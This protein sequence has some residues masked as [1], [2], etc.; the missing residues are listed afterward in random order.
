MT[1]KFLSPRILNLDWGRIQIDGFGEFKDVKLYPGGARNWS[2]QETGTEHSPGVQFADVQELLDHGAEE[3]ILTR[4]I[5]GRLKVQHETVSKLEDMG[6]T[7]H[8][9]HTKE[10]VKL[11]NVLREEKKVGGLFHNTC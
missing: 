10:A 6:I 2:W 4:G 1:E 8:V 11:Y 7:V 5:L 9:L 3:V